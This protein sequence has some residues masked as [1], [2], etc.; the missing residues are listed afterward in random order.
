MHTHSQDSYFE[1]ESFTAAPFKCSFDFFK[2]V[3][4]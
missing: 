3:Q 2:S 4:N 1:K